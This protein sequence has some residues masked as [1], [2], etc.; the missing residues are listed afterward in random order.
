MAEFC[1]SLTVSPTQSPRPW[2]EQE[3]SNEP[4]PVAV[5][6]LASEPPSPELRSRHVSPVHRVSTKPA[7]TSDP[8][9]TP[10][11]VLPEPAPIVASASTLPAPSAEPAPAES[12]LCDTWAVLNGQK[13]DIVIG[14]VRPGIAYYIETTAP[15]QWRTYYFRPVIG[16][17]TPRD[18]RDLPI[19]FVDAV[20]DVRRRDAQDYFFY[21]LSN[22]DN[23][24]M[25]LAFYLQW[26][27]PK[28]RHDLP[29]QIDL[30]VVQRW[31]TNMKRLLH[32][33]KC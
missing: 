14:F 21:C 18:I 20:N 3:A 22:Q 12:I 16:S 4:A 9:P 19:P 6:A 29:A 11:I 2:V 1:L 10:F 5:T 13:R 32:K 17:G 7:P 28:S 8:A 25:P 33:R 27:R 26:T 31:L 15:F 23:E 30:D 24:W